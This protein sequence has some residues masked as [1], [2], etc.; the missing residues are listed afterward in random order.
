M[1]Y[2]FCKKPLYEVTKKLTQ[3]AL[4]NEPA[5]C[6]IKN[7]TLINVCTKEFME[8]TDIVISEERICLIGDGSHCIGKDTTV[9]DATGLYAS[10]AFIDAHLH[11]ESSML[12]AKEYARA[13]IPHGTATICMDPHEICNVLGLE[14]LDYLLRDAKR[15]PLKVLAFVPS[16]VPSMPGFEDSGAVITADDVKKIIDREDVAGIGE[17][18]NYVGIINNLQGPHDI[19]NSSLAIQKPVS[20]HFSTPDTGASLNAYFSCGVNDCHE[21]TSADEAIEK[22]RRGVKVFLREGSASKNLKDLSRLI[23]EYDVDTR[24]TAFC[25]D[26]I[27]PAELI[28]NGH[29]DRI[30]RRAIA[31]GVPAL[32]AYQIATINAAEAYGF[33][34]EAGSISLGHAAD[35]ILIGDVNKVDV[36]K[37]IING[38]VVAEN[39][40]NTFEYSVDTKDEIESYNSVNIGRDLSLSDFHIDT[41]NDEETVRVIEINPQILITSSTTAKIKSDK[42]NLVSDVDQDVLK[43]VVFERHHATG[44]RG[45]GFI[46]GFGIKCGAI[47]STVAHDCHNLMVVGASDEDML[48]AAQTLASSGGGMCA[49]KDGKVIAHLP[50]PV[51]GLMSLK[52]AEDT[53]NQVQELERAWEKLDCKI[54]DP[55]MTMSFLSLA[56]IP[57]LRL[58]NR[59]LVDTDEFKFVDLIIK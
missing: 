8:N 41:K 50:L 39:G 3:V 27:H 58:T 44:L 38:K 59:G 47:A 25:T 5:D 54:S 36:Q 32:T 7:A 1:K 46:K 28:N 4:G 33:A 11:I 10:P 57:S 45:Y 31:L 22:L 42:N 30:V 53:A 14:G 55:F 56:C 49:V 13:V 26:D 2:T 23:T 6:V 43:A 34:H 12:T 35:I 20:G 48:V 15:T 24:Y 40:K 9:I 29:I 52:S 21:S 37:V 16:C 18:M 19:V 17:M 51:A